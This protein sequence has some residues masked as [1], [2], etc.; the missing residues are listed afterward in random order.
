MSLVALIKR[1]FAIRKKVGPA[2]KVCRSL[3]NLRKFANDRF[4]QEHDFLESQ[5]KVSSPYYNLT[6]L[7]TSARLAGKKKK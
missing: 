6:L 5:I 1:S 2:T 4:L 3:M 7:E